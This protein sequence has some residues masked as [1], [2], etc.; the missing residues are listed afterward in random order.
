MIGRDW[1]TVL[2]GPGDVDGPVRQAEWSL[3]LL[4]LES[5]SMFLVVI[6]RVLGALVERRDAADGVAH[7]VHARPLTAVPHG[8]ASQLFHMEQSASLLATTG[9]SANT[10][11]RDRR[12]TISSRYSIAILRKRSANRGDHPR[13][14]STSVVFTVPHGR[15]SGTERFPALRGTLSTRVFDGVALGSCLYKTPPRTTQLTTQFNLFHV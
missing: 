14:T 10:R 2:T 12:S 5:S 15:A 13:K 1:K 4:L 8:G 9:R 3:L 11:R 7:L 6:L